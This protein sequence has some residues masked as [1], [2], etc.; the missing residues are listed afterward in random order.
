M[1]HLLAYMHWNMLGNDLYSY[2]WKHLQ[3]LHDLPDLLYLLPNILPNIQVHMSNVLYLQGTTNVWRIMHCSDLPTNLPDLHDSMQPSDMSSDLPN[4]HDS[5][6]PS[7]MSS[8]LPDL[9][10][11]LQN[12]LHVLHVRV[13][14][15]LRR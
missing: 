12:L 3:D 13:Q 1:Q 6:R 2:M 14:G 11:R 9:H 8:D 4:M 7:D 15:N 5:M 10:H